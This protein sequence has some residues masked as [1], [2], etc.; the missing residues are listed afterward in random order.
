M[1]QQ[2]LGPSGSPRRRWTVFVPL[3]VAF[4]LGLMYI[5]GASAQLDRT[6]FELD[7]DATNNLTFTKAGVL[8]AAV[9]SSPGPTT[10]SICVVSPTPPGFPATLN[11]ETVLVDAERMTLSAEASLGG[12][13]CPAGFS[14]KRSYSAV[15]GVGTTDPGAHAKAEDVSLIV[16]GTDATMPGNDWDQIEAAA[17]DCESLGAV[18]CTFT[19]DDRG[20]S[21]FTQSKDFDEISGVTPSWQWRDQSVPDA[22]E[23]DDGFAAKYIDADGDQHLYFGAD[24]FAVNGTKDAGFWFFHDDVATVDPVGGADGTFTG[25]HTEPEDGGGDGFCNEDAGGSVPGGQPNPTPACDYDTNDSAGDVLI[26]TTFTGGGAT[27]TIRVF[28]WIGPAGTTA[29]LLER[30]TAADCVPGSSDQELCATVNNTTVESPWNYDGKSE[31]A[32]NEIAAGGFLEGGINLSDLGLE[33][34]F[35]SFMAASRSS[36]SLT[37][38]PKD[39][40]LGSFE[41]CGVGI[42]TTP[43]D[44][45]GNPITEITLGDSIKDHAVVQGTGGGPDPTGTVTFFICAPDELDVPDDGDPTTPDDDPNTCDVGGTQVGTPVTLDGGLDT[46]DA[47]A[48][49]DS[50]LFEPD[51]VGTWCWRGE[52]SGDDTYSPATDSSDGE[53][54]TV[55]DTSSIVTDQEWVPNDTATVSTAGGSNLTG[56]LT[57]TLYNNGTCDPGEAG[58]NILYQEVFTITDEASVPPLTRTTTN[59]DGIGTGLETDV[60]FHEADSPVGA[61][62]WQAVF[63]GTPD[64]TDSTSP[65]ETTS[66]FTIDDDPTP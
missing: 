38:D 50:I 6:L 19:H 17:P 23:L 45:E 54:F 3:L 62:S 30:G 63:D 55:I 40:I 49:A 15:R 13:G 29:A 26:L 46:T 10:I 8:N 42:V 41:A 11:G 24:R 64:S 58:A 27:V 61:L 18:A 31:P 14:S 22:D 53:C 57:M 52:Y 28:E 65:C 34:C 43:T 44:G 5:A 59:G 20:T 12:G 4:A 9:A 7:K 47:R 51:A 32:D 2:I 39:F 16:F 66:Q 60:I 25:V 56:T 48:T 37:A 35:S 33:G 1:T 21:I 36:D